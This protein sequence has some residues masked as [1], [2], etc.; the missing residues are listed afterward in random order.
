MLDGSWLKAH[1]PWP[2]GPA[3]LRGA[4]ER[5]ARA[6]GHEGA[7][8]GPRAGLAPLAQEPGTMSHE[9]SS[10]HQAIRLLGLEP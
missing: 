7:S 3:R 10:M 9:P 6:R 2:R 8:P 4:G 5:Q 1:G